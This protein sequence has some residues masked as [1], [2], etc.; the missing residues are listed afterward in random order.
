MT[1]EQIEAVFAHE[2]GH[3]VHR[4]MMWYLVLI[5]LLMLRT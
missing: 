1:D 2:V 4:H 5:V 3:I